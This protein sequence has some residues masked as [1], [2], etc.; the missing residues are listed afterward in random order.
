MNDVIYTYCAAL[1]QLVYV[2]A[3]DS[4]IKIFPNKRHNSV[5]SIQDILTF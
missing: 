4:R 3:C 5:T 1:D 2:E